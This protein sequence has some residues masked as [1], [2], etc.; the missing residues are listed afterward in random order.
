LS[1]ESNTGK[2]FY[3]NYYLGVKPSQIGAGFKNTDKAYGISIIDSDYKIA[4]E[5]LQ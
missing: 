1:F 5:A 3:V 4:K 2:K